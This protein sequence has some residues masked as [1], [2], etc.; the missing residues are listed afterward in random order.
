MN[1]EVEAELKAKL[2]QLPLNEKVKCCALY[3]HLSAVYEAQKDCDNKN[4]KLTYGFHQTHGHLLRNI[5][6]IVNGKELTDADLA[7]K[8][9]FFTAE[10]LA[11]EEFNKST[12]PLSDYALT[13]LKKSPIVN[14]TIKQYD[15]PILKHLTKVEMTPFEDKDD[16]ELKF[17]FSENEYFDNESINVHVVVDEEEG[18][19]KEIKCSAINWKE[20]KNVTEKTITK[21]QKNKRTG[22]NRTVTKTQKQE[23]FFLIFKDRVADKDEDDEEEGNENEPELDSFDMA[24]E[25]LGQIQENLDYFAP[26]YY[27]V[28]VPQWEEDAGLDGEDDDD[29]EDDDDDEDDGGKKKGGKKG[30]KGGAPNKEEC[31]QN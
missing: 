20:G 8:E 9:D 3:Q 1:K 29:Y 7:G 17:T 25:I 6:D 31:K 16:Y 27:G 24:A 14:E 22:Q 21:K 4:R 19:A 10:E 23:S 12:E 11:S 13:I 26:I 5:N 15:E 18:E 30:G 2:K 28:K